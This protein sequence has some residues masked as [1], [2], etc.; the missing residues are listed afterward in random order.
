MANLSL[1]DAFAKYG[2]KPANRLHSLSAMAGDGAMILGCGSTRF[3][4]SRPR[5][6]AIRRQAVERSQPRGGVRSAR[7]SPEPARDGKLPVRMIVIA[8]KVQE[9]GT[10]SREIHI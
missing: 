8:S 4:T 1:V 5:H 10:A 3:K 9:G 6:P 7:S 2:A